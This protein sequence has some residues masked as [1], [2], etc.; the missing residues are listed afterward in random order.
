MHCHGSPNQIKN[1]TPEPSSRFTVS[2]I[3]SFRKKHAPRPPP[4]LEPYQICPG[5]WNT[6]ATAK[7][8]GY[9]D[10]NEA[11]PRETRKERRPR[12]QH[13]PPRTPQRTPVFVTRLLHRYREAHHDDGT[14]DFSCHAHRRHIEAQDRRRQ[15]NRDKA[16]REREESRRRG[17]GYRM[18]TVSREDELMQRGANPRTGIVSPY[19]ESD[20]SRESIRCDYLAV[21]SVQSPPQTKRERSGRWK[22]DHLGWSLV[23]SPLL[24]PSS[25]GTLGHTA[26]AQALQDKFVVD[27][28]GVD[29][30][31]PAEMTAAQIERYQ[32]GFERICR[33]DRESAAMAS[34]DCFPSQRPRTPEHQSMPLSRGQ[35]IRRKE[36]GSGRV[37]R[38]GSTDT[39][40]VRDPVTASSSSTPRREVHEER[41][42]RIVTPSRAPTTLLPPTPPFDRNLPISYPYPHRDELPVQKTNTAQSASRP[43]MHQ[44]INHSIPTAAP[45][46]DTT[47]PIPPSSS[48]TLSQYLPRLSFLHPSNFAS[49]TTSYRRPAELLPTRLRPVQKVEETKDEFSINDPATSNK[50]SRTGQRPP[51]QR[52]DGSI[53]LPKMNVSGSD[54]KKKQ[55]K[56]VRAT[57]PAAES[58]PSTRPRTKNVDLKYFDDKIY[59]EWI[60]PDS[61]RVDV[62]TRRGKPIASKKAERLLKA[63][64]KVPSCSILQPK[65]SPS[66]VPIVP[67]QQ[68]QVFSGTNSTQERLQNEPRPI[69]IDGNLDTKKN[70]ETSGV[71]MK[72]MARQQAE[73]T[74]KP[75]LD[76]EDYLELQSTGSEWFAG[77]WATSVDDLISHESNTTSSTEDLFRERFGLRAVARLWRLVV[78]MQQKLC[79]SFESGA[80]HYRLM[81]MIRHVLMTLHASSPA[82][83][84]F[85]GADARIEDYLAA[86]KDI[87]LALVY[88][89]VLLNIFMVVGKVF[90]LVAK[91]ITLLWL[92][93][94]MVLVVARWFSVS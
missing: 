84:V 23:E 72:A 18:R 91:V 14:D 30:P 50:V 40:I 46:L 73:R 16:K 94:K 86:I 11:L 92:P 39:I 41:R 79:D 64:S 62:E 63:Q 33:S 44:G 37:Q 21:G 54:Q 15:A 25:G 31:E 2:I 78:L 76:P 36:V 58:F 29:N 82:F 59:K 34:L 22:Q 70:R 24:G 35:K 3:N 20:D 87:F 26:S 83:K 52:Q 12:G 81:E 5:T 56:D 55:N 27:M 43:T 89:L 53:T 85:R 80:I 7:V 90:K 93:F 1:P 71:K 47:T 45:T 19:V 61:P 74:K 48:L 42:V 49:L 6:D 10:S 9:L 68:R 13:S 28:P 4:P 60:I 75:S 57:H 65:G 8:F 69:Q 51:M 17:R 66:G 88:L 32:E 67:F 38:S 77:H